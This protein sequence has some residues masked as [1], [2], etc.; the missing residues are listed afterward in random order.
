LPDNAGIDVL[1]E[2]T[3]GNAFPEDAMERALH[4]IQGS[5]VTIAEGAVGWRELSGADSGP[6][7]FERLMGAP[8]DEE[9]QPIQPFEQNATPGMTMTGEE[10]DDQQLAR[11]SG[12]RRSALGQ[13]P[14]EAN[15]P[16]WTVRGCVPTAG[17]DH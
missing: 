10:P 1:V 11:I 2:H 12:R 13:V 14:K 6:V 9:R 16:Q 17:G 15:T 7:E 4:F 5:Q 3:K 8:A